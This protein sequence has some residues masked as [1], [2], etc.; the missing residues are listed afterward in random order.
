[1]YTK[2]NM[3]DRI[4]MLP[5]KA[6]GIWMAA[7]N[8]AYKEYDKDEEKSNATA[9]A[10]IKKAGYGKDETS[11]EWKMM[12]SASINELRNSLQVAAN[13]RYGSMATWVCDV[14]PDE[15]YMILN[16]GD[17]LLKIG[18][19]VVDGK[20]ALAND[21]QKVERK[22]TFIPISEAFNFIG[23]DLVESK[24]GKLVWNV[25]I[26]RSGLS[27]N[28]NYYPPEVL[29]KATPLFE[30]VRSHNRSD[31]EHCADINATV[32]N[33]AGWLSKPIFK[34]GKVLGKYHFANRNVGEV[35]AE[36]WKQGKKDLI[37][38]SIVAE[39]KA[40]R[41]KDGDKYIN[42]VESI[43]KVK[44][45]DLVLNPAAGGKFVQMLTE[46]QQTTGNINKEGSKLDR[47]KLFKLIEG[48]DKFAVSAVH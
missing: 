7:Y 24:P 45:V 9:W 47:E 35:V 44:S 26:I 46:A 31:A 17:E 36:A 10:A 30:G 13:E 14:F 40:T 20:I 32:N 23:V 8:S 4:K 48:K 39:G 33:V 28:N 12:E 29:S 25:E 41:K 16:Q 18:Y 38:L 5:E 19:S 21:T 1:M 22:E 15:N 6:M 37:G 3:P 2:D 34:E 43:N 27:D 11:G 42:Y